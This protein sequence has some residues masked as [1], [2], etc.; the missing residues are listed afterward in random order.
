MFLLEL[1]KERV[2]VCA[3]GRESWVKEFVGYKQI[4]W[5]FCSNKDDPNRIS[6]QI[7]PG[8]K[9][10]KRTKLWWFVWICWFALKESKKGALQWKSG[11]FVGVL[12]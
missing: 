10:F 7:V 5:L 1:N 8:V 4:R 2:H 9:V 3:I 12:Y 6:V 11:H